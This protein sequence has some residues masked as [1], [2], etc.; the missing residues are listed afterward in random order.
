MLIRVAICVSVKRN[1]SV[2]VDGF[3]IVKKCVSFL[4]VEICIYHLQDYHTL[5]YG[6]PTLDQ[7]QDWF[8][9]YGYEEN[10]WTVLGFHR[11]L[12]TCDA[13]GDRKITVRRVHGK[14]Q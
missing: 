5:E 12:D 1:G 11:R 8:I 9:D 2:R 7:S 3:G 13:I 10:G 14:Q 4:A 6:H